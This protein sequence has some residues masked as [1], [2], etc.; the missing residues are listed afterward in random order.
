MYARG[1]GRQAHRRL[2]REIVYHSC[3][4][5]PQPA[6]AAPRRGC[7]LDLGGKADGPSRGPDWAYWCDVIGL[8]VAEVQA[9]WKRL[10]AGSSTD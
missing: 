10:S 9:C 1:R 6:D 7:R 2:G 8:P 5:A 4:T 3:D